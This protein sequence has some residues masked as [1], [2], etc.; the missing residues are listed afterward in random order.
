RPSGA[1]AAT[2]KAAKR[3]AE[4]ME[5][6][7]SLCGDKEEEQKRLVARFGSSD[8]RVRQRGVASGGLRLREV[9]AGVVGNAAEPVVKVMLLDSDWSDGER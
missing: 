8:R 2:R 3:R 4:A 6:S 7:L 5:S 9:V 1:T